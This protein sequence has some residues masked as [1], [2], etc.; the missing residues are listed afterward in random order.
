MIFRAKTIRY[1][2]FFLA[3]IVAMPLPNSNLTGILMWASPYLFINSLFAVKSLVLLNILGFFTL[4]IIFFKNRWICRYICPLG[5]VC[6]WS[7]KI[8]SEK[9]TI[10]LNLNKYLLISSLTMAL[11][12]AP[13]LIVFDPFNI[14]HM[15]FEGIRTGFHFS[16][17]LKMS[18]LAGIVIL[19]IVFPNIWCRSICPLGGLQLL[20]FDLGKIIKKSNIPGKSTISG[21]RVFISGFTGV[22]AALALP[23]ISNFFL[24]KSIRPP[25]SF[26][27]PE[28]NLICIRCGNCSSACPTSIIKPADDE[29]RIG[30]LLS[31]V[32]DFSTSYCLP[33]CTSC[34]DVCPSGA[35]T[36]FR[37]EQKKDLFMASVRID[38]DQCWLQDQRDCNL[39][40]YYC[41]Y[42]A[43]E[44]RKTQESLLALPILDINKCVGCAACKIV[45]P[46]D[47]ITMA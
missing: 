16:A 8:R 43:M 35:I 45:C 30:S 39:C 24:I 26:P 28:M 41:A 25:G 40:R 7:S 12:V 5:V 19:N 33:E 13:I 15:S 3:I 34:G 4:L 20:T 17:Y 27:E 38:I 22:F 1:L 32:I 9:D 44:I 11:F 14:F 42:D 18:F 23:R 2:F 21:R 10:K 36:K 31:P 29:T 37:K 46:A 47:A 6:D